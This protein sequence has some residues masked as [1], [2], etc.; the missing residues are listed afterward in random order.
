MSDILHKYYVMPQPAAP[1]FVSRVSAKDA[2]EQQLAEYVAKFISIL[3][4]YRDLW[5]TRPDTVTLN[6]LS[7]WRASLLKTSDPVPGVPFIKRVGY[8][9]YS[10]DISC[11]KI[12][13]YVKAPS[14]KQVSAET[15]QAFPPE[16]TRRDVSTLLLLLKNVCKILVDAHVFQT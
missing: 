8:T 7:S 5:M 10:Q 14:S 16:R 3:D 2:T 6:T 12:R 11:D 15:R 1:D 13:K 9:I 4:V